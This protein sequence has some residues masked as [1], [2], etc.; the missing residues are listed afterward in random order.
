M[1]IHQPRN[2]RMRLLNNPWIQVIKPGIVV[3]NAIAVLG[4]F[5]LASRGHFQLGTLCLALL[6]TMLVIASGCVVNNIIDRDIDRHMS[7][8]ANRVLVTGRLS[9]FSAA[10]YAFILL[11]FGIGLLS[12]T[13][14]LAVLSA[15]FGYV[16]YVGFYSLYFKRHSVLG[17]LIGSFSGAIPPVIGYV[18]VTNQMDSAYWILFAMFSIWQLPHAYAIA[19]FRYQDYQNVNIPVL[20]LTVSFNTAKKHIVTTILLFSILASLLVA[21]NYTGWV[22][23]L[24][25]IGSCGLWLKNALSAVDAS[26]LAQAKW[27]RKVFLHSVMTI[28]LLSIAMGIPY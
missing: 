3:G 26:Q 28:T 20:P 27:A 9:I 18:A 24:V 25:L 7:R 13:G 8:T 12:I 23:L 11:I 16:I 15:L 5:L 10:I 2:I 22:Y 17:T 4:G 14:I 19:I 1:T 21:F 6:G